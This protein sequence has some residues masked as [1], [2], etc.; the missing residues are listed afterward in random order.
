[1][2][3]RMGTPAGKR[4]STAYIVVAVLMALMMFFSASGKLTL[5]PAV[6]KGIHE[7]VGVPLN[8]LPVLALLEIAGG[9]GLLAGIVRPKLGIAGAIGLVCYFVGAFIAHVRVADW[10]GLTGPIVPFVFAVAALILRITS[11]RRA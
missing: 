4:L 3:L 9:I 11:A 5:N 2:L 8:L 7:V 1:M 10:A 6:V